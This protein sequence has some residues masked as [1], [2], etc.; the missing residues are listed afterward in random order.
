MRTGRPTRGEE[1][2]EKRLTVR[3]TASEMEKVA[4]LSE[5]LGVSKT[6][7][8]ITAIDRLLKSIE[9]DDK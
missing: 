5:R 8:V 6:Q 9:E 3:L 4:S 1:K 2:R 7:G